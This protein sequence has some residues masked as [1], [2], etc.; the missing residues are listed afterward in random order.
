MEGDEKTP[1]SN[2][3]TPRENPFQSSFVDYD[4][5]S[6]EEYFREMEKKVEYYKQHFPEMYEKAVKWM[7]MLNQS[8]VY[9]ANAPDDPSLVDREKE[10]ATDLLKNV[11]YNGW[12]SSDLNQDEL[13]LLGKYFPNWLDDQ[14][15]D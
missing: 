11:R 6:E 15:D 3:K 5:M 10:K 13:A 1:V 9:K 7:E 12:T 14:T 2:E 4:S 8:E